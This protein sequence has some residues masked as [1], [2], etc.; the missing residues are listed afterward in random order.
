MK[1]L[2]V[3]LESAEPIRSFAVLRLVT[4]FAGLGAAL[5]SDVPHRDR[6]MLVIVLVGLP[7]A[8]AVFVLARRAPERALH[9]LVALGDLLILALAEL[10]APD[11]YAGIRFLAIF[12]V[13]AHAHFQGEPGGVAFAAITLA[14]LVPLVA[15]DE[16]PV[17]GGR[18]I[19]NECIFAVATLSAGVFMARLRIA[20]STGRLR[21]RQLSRRTIE[22]E[23]GVRRRLAE[24][25]HDGPV[26][27]LVSLD[28][29]LDAARRALDRDDQPRARELLTEAGLVAERNIGALRDEIVALG[30]YAFDEL[31]IDTALE[32]CVPTWSR[33]Y[34]VEIGMSIERLDL[35]NDACG[36]LFG[37]VQEAVA[38][39]GRHAG[40]EQISIS[41]RTVDGEVELRVS[42]NGRGFEDEQPLGPNEPGHIGLAT[43]RERAE[44][45]GGRLE[46]RSG[47]TGST[48]LALV[49]LRSAVSGDSS[50]LS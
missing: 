46:I 44:L 11:T 37:I 47:S 14:V 22:A 24:A 31:T 20:E 30:P 6:L 50:S 41:L 5:I 38:N 2:R 1:H 4:V 23:A 45:L 18:L 16:T 15:L 36:S 7:W 29:M 33:R 12:L 48:V 43:M 35:T 49:P 40:A 10:A 42:D 39:A 21:A 27:E 17:S 26:Q 28:M 25:I 19:F 32:Q 13:A 3:P 8:A 9:P 34:G